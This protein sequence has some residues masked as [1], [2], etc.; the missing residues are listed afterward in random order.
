[1]SKTTKLNG[2]ERNP[3]SFMT[4]GGLNNLHWR[5]LPVTPPQLFNSLA[6]LNMKR[7][8]QCQFHKCCVFC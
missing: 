2:T 1:M 3:A 7:E 6:H 8:G 5:V 4:D